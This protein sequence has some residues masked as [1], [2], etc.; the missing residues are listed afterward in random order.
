MRVAFLGPHGTFSEE[1]ATRC[2]ARQ[3][4]IEFAPCASILDVL[5]SVALGRVEIGVVP[6]ENSLEGSVSM[7]LDG[8]LLHPDLYVNSEIALPISHDLVACAG[9]RIDKIHYVW[10]H[11]QALAQCRKYIH[12]LSATTQPFASTAAAAQA[13]AE[14]NRMD[15]GAI[16]TSWAAKL[17]GLCTLETGIQ[18]VNENYTRFITVRKGAETSATATKTML[19]ITPCEENF[20]VLASILNIF[21]ALQLNLTWIESHPTKNKLGQ[22]Q[23]FT[24][25]QSALHYESV[26][27][28]VHMVETLG[29]AV[30]VLGA[31]CVRTDSV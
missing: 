19:V 5:Q 2:Y 14:A 7:T 11:P 21:A 28:A 13:V 15:V 30:R 18:D 9:A 1:A 8:L 12:Q 31:Y 26:Q 6:I 20:G 17:F 27:K 23:F 24:D 25:V 22:Y 16:A 3:P 29:H 10:S 4:Q